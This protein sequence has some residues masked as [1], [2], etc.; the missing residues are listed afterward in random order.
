MITKVLIA[1][2]HQ[3]ANLSLQKTLSDLSIIQVDTVYYCDDALQFV[4]RA[5]Q[6]KQ[7][8]DLL[9]T[10]LHFETDHRPQQLLGGIELIGA[11]KEVQPDLKVLIFSAETKPSIIKMLFNDKEI[12]GYVRKARNDSD[13]L[14]AAIA[15]ISENRRYIPRL[16]TSIL[17]QNNS[18]HF[19]DFDIT[20]ISLLAQGIPQKNIPD[21][22]KQNNIRPSGLS[23]VEKRLNHIREMLQIYKNEQLVI[24]CR[25][26]GVI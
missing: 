19:T 5:C 13:E 1:E 7:T 2:D 15:T 22:L 16:F 17:R 3:S 21:Y 14:K 4:Q 26:I 18:Y 24:F 9:I 8:Y 20:L 25:E 6:T 10:D 12:D 11:V 23:S